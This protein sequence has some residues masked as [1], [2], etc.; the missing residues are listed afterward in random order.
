M[1]KNN[2]DL[3]LTNLSTFYE[4]PEK[5]HPFGLSDHCTITFQPQLKVKCR[6]FKIKCR[7]LKQSNKQQLGR[8]LSSIDWS[9]LHSVVSAEDKAKLLE[10]FIIIGLDNIMP[11][12]VIKIHSNDAPWMTTD[13]KSQIKKRQMAL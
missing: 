12:R 1:P 9:E 6:P 8:Y 5:I 13:L 11:E 7:D 4:K 3:I 10:D 2:L